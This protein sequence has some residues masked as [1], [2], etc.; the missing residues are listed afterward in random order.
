MQE[1]LIQ[2]RLQKVWRLVDLTK[3]KHAIGRKWVYRNNKDEREIKR[4]VIFGRPASSYGVYCLYQI[5]VRGAFLYGTIEDEV[6]VCQPPSFEDPQFPNKVYKVEKAL[7]GLHQAPSA[8]YETLSTYLLENG[9]RRGIID[10]TLFIK[11]NK[12]DILL[13]QVY[14]DDI[15][16]GLTKKSLCTEFEGT[17]I[18]EMDKIK[19]KNGH[20]TKHEKG[21]E[22]TEQDIIKLM[23]KTKCGVNL[24]LGTCLNCT[25]GDGKPVTCC[26][27]EGP[28]RGGF[29][30]FCASR[31]GN[32]F[33]YNP[34]PNSFNESQNFSDYPPQPQYETN[35]CE[36]CG[37]DVHYDYD[38]LPQ[39]P[40][41]YNQNLCFDQNFDNNFPLT[42]PSFSQQYLCC[43]NCEGSHAT[44]Q[45]QPMNQNL[46]NSNSSSFDQFQPPQYPVIHHS[47]QE[48]SEEVLK[49]REDLMKAIYTFLR[50]FSRIPFGVT[51]KDEI[52]HEK[53]LNVNLLVDKIEAL[54]LT[55]SIP[56]V[57]E[58]PS[59]SPIPVVDSDFL[60]E[61]VDTFVV[62]EDSI[63]PGIESDF[64]LE[65]DI[66][67]LENLLNEY[68][69]P[70]Y[71]RFTFDIEPDAPMINNF[72]EFNEDECFYPGGGEIDVS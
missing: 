35:I 65:G 13:V 12:G 24:L 15:I 4:S 48:T 29:C 18:K 3:G 7:Y 27:C 56:F 43:E 30:S 71:E 55:P 60:V 9:F 22:C 25:Y 8:W 33:D 34:N 52:L 47:P 31:D 6:Y 37:N 61:D 64:D 36:L 10:K 42:S 49:A 40:F 68:P 23:I 46:S 58:Y 38:C 50:K 41:V 20:K 70:E 19:A 45:C 69:I 26:G 51:P 14:V 1:E 63:P 11:E 21:Q 39:V 16:F 57:L 72:D 44:F 28:L 32:S 17:N 5:D 66:I 2:F 67:F 53:L 62:S 54:K 59:Y